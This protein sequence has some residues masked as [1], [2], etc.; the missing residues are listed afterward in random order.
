[1]TR[2]EFHGPVRVALAAWFCMAACAAWGEPGGP[3]ADAPVSN[4]VGDTEISDTGIDETGRLHLEQWNLAPQEYLR[5]KSLMAGPRGSFSVPNISPLEVLGIHARTSRERREY[6]DRLV[7]LQY[8]DTER[9]LAF[10]RE[11]QAAWRRLGKPMFDPARFSPGPTA[12]R[13]FSGIVST[14]IHR[15][16]RLALFVAS[17]DCPACLYLTRQLADLP[18]LPGLD[19][20]VTDT[21]DDDA[22]RDFA[23]QAG[24]PKAAVSERRITLNRGAALAGIFQLDLD[25]AGLPMLFLRDGDRLVPATADAQQSRSK[26][27]EDRE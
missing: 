2:F 18:E 21:D 22:I 10:E 16:Q 25:G 9:V 15:K 24:I 4:R 8:E 23:R 17:R 19:V 11:V 20:Y 14:A 12:N 13:G 27:R 1:M 6:A 7:R 26:T 5:Y 3:G